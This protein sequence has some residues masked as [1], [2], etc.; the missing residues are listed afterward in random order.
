[1]TNATNAPT[2]TIE[3]SNA[4]AELASTPDQEMIGYI[5]YHTLASTYIEADVVNDAL[6]AIKVEAFSGWEVTGV[7]HGTVFR[8]RLRAINHRYTK[9]EAKDNSRKVFC[10][11]LPEDGDIARYAVHVG[12]ATGKRSHSLAQ[13]AIVE[14]DNKSLEV[15]WKFM[16]EARL[17]D[18]AD[19]AYLARMEVTG[20]ASTYKEVT[21]H[22]VQ[23]TGKL[24]SSACERIRNEGGKVDNSRIHGLIRRLLYAGEMH[25]LNLRA[26]GGIYFVPNIEA[27]G[28][29]N[30]AHL[31]RLLGELVERVGDNTL[32]LIPQF[33][34]EG[35]I[36]AI[37]AGANETLGSKIAELEEQMKSI[38]E[39]SRASALASKLGHIKNVMET[40]NV[41][42]DL[43][44]FKADHLRERITQVETHLTDVI[45]ER[46]EAKAAKK[47]TK[48]EKKPAFDAEAERQRIREEVKAEMAAERERIRAEL[49]AELMES[50][51]VE[52]ETEVGPEPATCL[53]D[54]EDFSLPTPSQLRAAAK[55]A[56]GSGV[57]IAG[58]V[59][60]TKDEHGYAW[61]VKAEG[62]TFGSSHLPSQAAV[63]DSV[64]GAVQG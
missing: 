36:K 55:D 32:Y 5:A 48:R 47:T 18:E 14:L 21:P 4:T 7:E 33:A 22:D 44:E 46:K 56:K 26:T 31:M 20:Y 17:R 62:V 43:V 35:T 13:L 61:E 52:P 15:S 37:Q 6:D 28:D 39:I 41:Y 63:I 53:A 38:E 42:A 2:S 1:M 9:D 8:R 50:P 25:I 54:V 27:R 49:M 51:L 59:I 12:K 34:K 60:I 3:T 29:E 10:L 23:V 57:G 16:N 24:I 40:A 64:L 58:R 30:P 11:E 19:D 45:N